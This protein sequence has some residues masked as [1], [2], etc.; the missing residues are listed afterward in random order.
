[1]QICVG[2][3]VCVSGWVNLCVCVWVSVCVWVW[4]TWRVMR[5]ALCARRSGL[6]VMRA[7]TGPFK[8]LRTSRKKAVLRFYRTL[9]RRP[10]PINYTLQHGAAQKAKRSIRGGMTPQGLRPAFPLSKHI[11][12]MDEYIGLCLPS[13]CEFPSSTSAI[14]ERYTR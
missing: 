5:L 13:E 11:W 8:G 12:K 7:D 1:M 2:Q 9:C 14:Y 10:Q 4:R 6:T 3:H